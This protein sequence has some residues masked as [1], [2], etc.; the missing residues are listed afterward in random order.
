MQ[1]RFLSG[2]VFLLFVQI[3]T[4]QQWLT[5]FD[6][7]QTRATAEEKAIILVFQGSDW[8]APCIRLDREV[9]ST[10]EFI[11]YAN[12]NYIMLKA[13]FPRKK[14]NA[15]PQKQAEANAALAER[16]NPRGIF[17]L[18]VILDATGQVM[19]QASYD[20]KS[21]QAYIELLESFIRS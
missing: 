11:E 5:D 13:D 7:A 1:I 4:A 18:V 21:P 9:W 17:P 8:C 20:R 2:L 16:Y 19:G 6:A 12:S 15:L 14:K 10:P 3:G